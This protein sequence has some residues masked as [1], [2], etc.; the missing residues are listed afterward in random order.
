M[1]AKNENNREFEAVCNELIELHQKKNA[2]Y[3][4]AYSDAYQKI[5]N[6]YAVGLLYNKVNRLISL[7]CDDKEQHVNDEPVDDTIKDLASYAIM[8]KMERDKKRRAESMRREIRFDNG[9]SV[10][11]VLK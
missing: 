8:L 10:Y 7:L 6:G 9:E 4:D 5:G 1:D 2:D 11:E 3:G